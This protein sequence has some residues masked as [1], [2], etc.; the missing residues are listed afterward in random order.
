MQ[1]A[2][3]NITTEVSFFDPRAGIWEL[4]GAE[5]KLHSAPGYPVQGKVPVRN[6]M[7]KV[8]VQKVSVL[9]FIPPYPTGDVL[10]E[11]SPIVQWLMR[12]CSA[13]RAS[14]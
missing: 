9:S 2:I 11:G 3:F 5:L 1:A 6:R 10:A 4:S 8:S 14:A 7:Q 13:T 12:I